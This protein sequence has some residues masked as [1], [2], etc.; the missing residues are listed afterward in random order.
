MLCEEK[1]SLLKKYEKEV[2]SYLEAVRRMGE[3]GAA[4]VATTTSIESDDGV[5]L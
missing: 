4:L 3:Y 5:R 1:Q 2:G